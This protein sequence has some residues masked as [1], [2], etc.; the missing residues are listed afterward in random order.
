MP[1]VCNNVIAGAGSNLTALLT[2]ANALA[3]Y[4][5][6]YN[7]HTYDPVDSYDALFAPA[8][9]VAQPNLPL[10]LTESGIHLQ[11]GLGPWADMSVSNDRRQ[12][13]FV[14]PSFV[15]SLFAG[16]CLLPKC[17]E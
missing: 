2:S 6:T 16:Q 15:V 12:A 8:R 4:M 17:Y 1:I 14:A 11:V 7:I 9:L 3:P 5:Q 10:W 13:T